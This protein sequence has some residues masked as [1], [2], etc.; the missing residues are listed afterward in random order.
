MEPTLLALRAEY[1]QFIHSSY[2]G[3][4]VQLEFWEVTMNPPKNT[5]NRC[6]NVKVFTFAAGWA[7]P[8]V[9]PVKLVTG[10][11]DESHTLVKF[12]QAW[13][14]FPSFLASLA[15]E[16]PPVD[17]DK[18]WLMW[19]SNGKYF[20]LFNLPRE[21][22]D[23]IYREV[24]FVGGDPRVFPSRFANSPGTCARLGIFRARSR[25]NLDILAKRR[26][27]IQQ[28]NREL[29]KPFP[30]G[31]DTCTKGKGGG[32]RLYEEA[33]EI[34]YSTGRFEFT[35][36][37]Q[38]RQIF[39]AARLEHFQMI[40]EIE[41]EFHHADYLKALGMKVNREHSYQVCPAMEALKS[42]ALR[43]LV[44]RMAS[45]ISLYAFTSDYADLWDYETGRGCHS[46]TVQW[47]LDLF[48]PLI[49]HLD[50]HR[51]EIFGYI[52]RPQKTRFYQTLAKYKE[53]LAEP[54]F[55][56]EEMQ[57]DDDD[58]GGVPLD[59]TDV[60][61]FLTQDDDWL[62]PAKKSYRSCSYDAEEISPD[63]EL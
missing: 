48:I 10:A 51:I 17:T 12:N 19:Q 52:K 29:S 44:I 59:G 22:R 50:A 34:L 15:P 27:Q 53:H 49:A 60:Q 3:F 16:D 42:L 14:P 7:P 47:I 36:P 20:P 33:V 41:F 8:Y 37:E 61:Q 21:L 40:R 54:T 56:V 24:I 2:A 43:R 30:R 13:S 23:R 28:Y 4:C 38:F 6:S 25:H 1:Q 63:F 31:Y 9:L 57:G 5:K 45:P 55:S 62:L 39:F 46:K 35:L 58:E 26:P 11:N 18:L 32:L